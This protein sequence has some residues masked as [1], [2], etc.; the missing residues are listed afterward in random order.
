MISFVLGLNIAK[1]IN[2]AP[3]CPAEKLHRRV[4]C[5]V[6]DGDFPTVRLSLLF[7]TIY[8]LEL[9]FQFHRFE[10]NRH[11]VSEVMLVLLKSGTYISVPGT[12]KKIGFLGSS[13]K[14]SAGLCMIRKSTREVSIDTLQAAAIDRVNQKSI[15]SNT[16]PSI[17][18]TCE[19]T[20]KVEGT[21]IPDNSTVTEEDDFELKP[22][23]I[24]LMEQR[25]FHGFPHEQAMDHIDMFEGLVLFIFNEVPEDHH[26]CKLFRNTLAGEATH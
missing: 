21:A 16:T 14:E 24:T 22:I 13:K 26:F 9:S 18:I 5:L 20:E 15:D 25:H 19:K 3:T 6:M 23:F 2:G 8:N 1:S 7:D 11:P 10:V 4:R 17:D 12:T